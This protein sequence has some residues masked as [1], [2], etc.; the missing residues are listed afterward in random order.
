MEEGTI[1]QLD[2]GKLER[3]AKVGGV[4]P[5]VIQDLHSGEVLILAYANR[6]ALE[7]SLATGKVVLWST[8]RNELWEKG[9]TS[10]SELKLVEVRVNCEQ[11]SLLYLVELLGEGS[12]HTRTRDGRYRKSCYYRR[13]VDGDEP[14]LEHLSPPPASSRPE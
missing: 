3:V 1:L 7:R 6:E 12:C 11:N 8:S 2:F 4:L 14:R 13:I 5:V 10:G 9:R